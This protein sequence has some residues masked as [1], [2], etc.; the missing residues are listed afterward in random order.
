M[1]GLGRTPTEELLA[2]TVRACWGVAMGSFGI[3]GG[4]WKS[5]S[6]TK[7][8]NLYVLTV[9]FDIP[10]NRLKDPTVPVEFE[11]DGVIDDPTV[12]V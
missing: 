8:G 7:L 11:N 1:W 6:A 3:D 10:V 9:W 12:G 4:T 5:R 2:T